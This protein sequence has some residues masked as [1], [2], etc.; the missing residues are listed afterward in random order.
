MKHYAD[1]VRQHNN[2]CMMSSGRRVLKREI[3]IAVNFLE[4]IGVTE[5]W[6]PDQIAKLEETLKQ[7]PDD[8]KAM[9]E[10]VLSVWFNMFGDK[11]R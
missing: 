8:E 10:N 1:Y 6:K 4:D 2:L 7:Y 3:Y 5:P 9:F 11:K